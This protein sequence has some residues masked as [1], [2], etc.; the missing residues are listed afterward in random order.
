[1]KVVRIRSAAA[2]VGMKER[3]KRKEKKR[4]IEREKSVTPHCAFAYKIAQL[5]F[6]LVALFQAFVCQRQKLHNC[7]LPAALKLCVINT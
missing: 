2:F 3:E 1:M 5:T 7:D 4:K 6:N